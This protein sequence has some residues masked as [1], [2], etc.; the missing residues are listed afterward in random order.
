MCIRDRADTDSVHDIRE[1]GGDHGHDAAV[2]LAHA[3]DL[4]LVSVPWIQRLPECENWHVFMGFENGEP[5]ALGSLYM[6]GDTAWTDFAATDPGFRRR[7]FQSALLR[8]RVRYALDMG[9]KHIHT[10]TGEAVPG[11]PQ[12]SYA[13][14]LKVGF[15]E[16]YLRFNYAPRA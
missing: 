10:C 5:A 6:D 14:I 1:I 7:G 15:R 4:G 12:H 3:F 16:E 13:N 11:D 2:I 8:H 9:C